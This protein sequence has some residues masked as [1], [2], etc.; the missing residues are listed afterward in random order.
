M[1]WALWGPR[2]SAFAWRGPALGVTVAW[3]ETRGGRTKGSQAWWTQFCP[4]PQDTASG[5]RRSHSLN[6]PS[7]TRILEISLASHLRAS[8]PLPKPEQR[9]A[10]S[11]LSCRWTHRSE[12]N[13]A[14]LLLGLTEK[15]AGP[16]TT[17][18]QLAVRTTRPPSKVPTL[19][20][21]GPEAGGSNDEDQAVRV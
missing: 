5:P 2:K 16:P 15:N 8:P 11:S 6:R 17:L 7:L 4:A 20:R 13:S 19:V 9:P 14:D 3:G 12:I 21:E 1:T 10:P 18:N